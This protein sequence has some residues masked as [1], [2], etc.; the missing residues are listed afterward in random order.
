[1]PTPK[2]TTKKKAPAGSTTL[3]SKRVEALESTTSK[4]VKP[5]K[6]ELEVKAAPVPKAE[7][8][9]VSARPARADDAFEPDEPEMPADFIPDDGG[10]DQSDEA[11]AQRPDRYFE[12]VGRRKSA[13]A[14]VRLFT[15]AGDFSVN[16]KPY[17]QYFTTIELRNI[18]EDSLKKMKLLGRFRVSAKMSGGGMHGQA[19]ET[20]DT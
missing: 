12:G 11:R 20:D 7:E 8:I 1:M 18:V 13:I 3:L 15:R 10:E 5:K 16:G 17:E 6:E 9:F 4:K 14:R 19:D 2:T